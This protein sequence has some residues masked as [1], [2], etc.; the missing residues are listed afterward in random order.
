MAKEPFHIAQPA[1]EHFRDQLV[2]DFTPDSS[3]GG[4]PIKTKSPEQM[5]RC[6]NAGRPC[7]CDGTCKREAPIPVPEV[8]A[9]YRMQNPQPQSIPRDQVSD[10]R[11]IQCFDHKGALFIGTDKAVYQLMEDNSLVCV[12]DNKSFDKADAEY[13]ARRKS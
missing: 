1:A 3:F 7:F 5:S 13:K 6:P 10:M 4:I 2:R 8:R 9:S 11:I 12:V